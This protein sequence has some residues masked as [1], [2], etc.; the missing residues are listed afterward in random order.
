VTWYPTM[1]L[2]GVIGG[3]AMLFVMRKQRR[4]AAAE[5]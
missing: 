3:C 1:I 4:L 2:F 5:A